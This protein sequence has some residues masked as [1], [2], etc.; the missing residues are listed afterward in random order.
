MNNLYSIGNQIGKIFH[1]KCKIK[2]DTCSVE[3][4]RDFKVLVQGRP[5]QS[6][7]PV[8]ISFESLD[9]N[10]VALNLAEITLLQEEI[11]GFIS[12]VVKQ[13]LIVSALHNHW[14]FTNPTLFYLHL[15]SV[16]PPLDFAKKLSQ[17]FRTLRNH[18]VPET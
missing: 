2:A 12:A 1:T 7:T 11:P 10:G 3:L 8:G 16:E 13:G 6:V 17:A 5:S 9:Q 15:Q 4:H 14:I 18:P